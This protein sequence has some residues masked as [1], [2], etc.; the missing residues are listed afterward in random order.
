MENNSSD[1]AWLKTIERKL[2]MKNH[3]KPRWVFLRACGLHVVRVSTTGS[4]RNELL[5]K[6][7]HF[8]HVK[9]YLGFLSWCLTVLL[10]PRGR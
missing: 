5:A 2:V 8:Q 3:L 6:T 7:L 4:Q 1:L 10:L 9:I